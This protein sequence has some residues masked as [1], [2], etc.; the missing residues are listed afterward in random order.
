M[1]NNQSG[2]MNASERFVDRLKTVV[3]AGV[4]VAAPFTLFYGVKHFKTKE[5]ALETTPRYTVGEVV[6]TGYVISPSSHGYT[7]F[8]YQ[9]GDSTHT[10]Y[11]DGR[12][13]AGLTRFLVK[14]S[15]KHPEY[16]EFYKH[17]PVPYGLSAP[18]EAGP[19]RPFP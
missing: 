6:K 19:S 1:S 4:F 17:A 18:P 2:E 13:P 3:A 9:V 16:Y 15:A 7:E 5:Y 8:V 12:L 14:F 11:D 10:G